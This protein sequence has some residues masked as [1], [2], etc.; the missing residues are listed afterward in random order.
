MPYEPRRCPFPTCPK[1]RKIFK[2][3]AGLTQ[4]INAVHAMISQSQPSLRPAQALS[5]FS[6]A[7]G[8]QHAM[9]DS[10][11]IVM[12]SDD[13]LHPNFTSPLIPAPLESSQNPRER[14]S[15]HPHLNGKDT[16]YIFLQVTCR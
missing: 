14:L 5:S 15:F 3:Q 2:S 11:M 7:D 1:P 6:P 13:I 9:V 4:H 16:T 10:E 12:G 8:L